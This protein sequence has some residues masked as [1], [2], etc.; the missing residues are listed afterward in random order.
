[1]RKAVIPV[2]SKGGDQELPVK[3]VI[4]VKAVI[5]VKTVIT[6]IQV[7]TVHM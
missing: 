4:T 3:I 7:K 5:Q 6:V 2:I 1:M